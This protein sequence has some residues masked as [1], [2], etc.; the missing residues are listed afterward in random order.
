MHQHDDVSCIDFITIMIVVLGLFFVF[1]VILTVCLC[2]YP[3]YDSEE[4]FSRDRRLRRKGGARS[5]SCAT[6]VV[7]LDGSDPPDNNENDFGK[8]TR[9]PANESTFRKP[10]TS[11]SPNFRKGLLRKER[12][13]RC[14]SPRRS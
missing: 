3:S 6:T 2:R 11:P 7:S 14:L 9:L 8:I 4:N 10:S 5:A 1:G 13:F 12:I